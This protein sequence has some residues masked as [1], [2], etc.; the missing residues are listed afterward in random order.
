MHNKIVDMVAVTSR[1]K[2]LSGGKCEKWWREWTTTKRGIKKV[3]T[4][5]T[6][7][8]KDKDTEL[9][10]SISETLQECQFKG[11]EFGQWLSQAERYD[12]FV[13]FQTCLADMHSWLG[14]KNFGF[15]HNI[16]VA[17]G[18]RGSRGALAHYEPWSNIINMTKQKGAGSFLHEYAHAIDYSVGGFFDQCNKYVA[19][20]GGHTM[21]QTTDNVGG[22][23]RAMINKILIYA[24]DT[25]SYKKMAK[26]PAFMMKLGY[27]GNSTE[28]FARLTETYFSYYYNK[29]N[30]YYLVKPSEYYEK[31]SKEYGMYLSRAEMDVIKPEIDKFWK[32][33]ALLLNNKCTLKKTPFPVVKIKPKNEKKRE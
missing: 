13:A 26:I 23:F 30:N 27:W 2:P 9:S 33:V 32:E 25:E 3:G 15:D 16:G 12:V 20:S 29:G 5:R 8:G 4:N 21:V 17:F 6:F 19:L 28:M 1:N 22:Q 31:R 24:R 7:A 10:P 11:F 14:T 18:A